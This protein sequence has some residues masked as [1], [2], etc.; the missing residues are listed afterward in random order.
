MEY[1]IDFMYEAIQYLLV[2]PEDYEFVEEIMW[3][4]NE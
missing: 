1:N 2:F 3:I 4:N